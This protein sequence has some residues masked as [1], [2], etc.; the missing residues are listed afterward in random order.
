MEAPE[1]TARSLI[2]GTSLCLWEGGRSS[3]VAVRFS[4]AIPQEACR[5]SGCSHGH[6][7]RD[8]TPCV[9]HHRRCGAKKPAAVNY[10][11]IRTVEKLCL[12][13]PR[14]APASLLVSS[15]AQA[16]S[17]PE[18]EHN[19]EGT[20]KS[21][22]S[23]TLRESTKRGLKRARANMRIPYLRHMGRHQVL[24]LRST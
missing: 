21:A 19:V 17:Q 8:H 9:C 4:K 24:S 18:A 5:S 13:D 15:P 7:H 6:Q 10:V 12:L 2:V 23:K 22:K 3:A 14:R 20:T 11:D 1:L 16:E